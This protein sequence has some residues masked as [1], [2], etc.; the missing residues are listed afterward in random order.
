MLHVPYIS[1]TFSDATFLLISDDEACLSAKHTRP[2]GCHKKGAA[3]EIS[4]IA[5][6][7]PQALI[8]LI[9]LDFPFRPKVGYSFEVC[10]CVCVCVWHARSV[11]TTFLC[12]AANPPDAAQG[13]WPPRRWMRALLGTPARRRQWGKSGGLGNGNEAV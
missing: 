2:A 11:I 6:T 5:T 10:P 3:G 12:P 9:H 4:L 8:H 1:S 13:I 7:I